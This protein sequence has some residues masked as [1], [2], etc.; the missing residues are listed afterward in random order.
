MGWALKRLWSG[1]LDAFR[2]YLECPFVR[3]IDA[4]GARGID[5]ILRVAVER[6]K[7]VTTLNEVCY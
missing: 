1:K 5:R 2:G 4:A 3:V 7:I 6:P